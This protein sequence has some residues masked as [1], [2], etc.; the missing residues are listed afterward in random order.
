MQNGGNVANN[1]Y[2][3]CETSVD[4]IQIVKL[5]LM[6][7]NK[8]N[9]KKIKFRLSHKSNNNQSIPV[10]SQPARKQFNE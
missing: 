7:L 9:D 8:S 4:G 1:N 10:C 6:V 3:N 5:Q 2:F